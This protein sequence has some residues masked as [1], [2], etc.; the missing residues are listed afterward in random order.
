MTSE[1]NLTRSLMHMFDMMMCSAVSDEKAARENKSLR[2]W[3]VVG[4]AK[5]LHHK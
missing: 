5:M 1:A 2:G 3:I 4:W